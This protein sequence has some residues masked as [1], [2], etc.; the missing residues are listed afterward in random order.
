MFE[1][2]PPPPAQVPSGAAA[3]TEKKAF[4]AAGAQAVK[5]GA[6]VGAPVRGRGPWPIVMESI[7]MSPVKDVPRVAVHCTQAVPAAIGSPT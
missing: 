6:A 3:A 5:V 7:E 4:G 2:N 1:V